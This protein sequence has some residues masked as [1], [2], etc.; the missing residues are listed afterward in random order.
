MRVRISSPR[1]ERERSAVVK[2][3][4][5]RVDCER[6]ISARRRIRDR[7]SLSVSKEQQA[8]VRSLAMRSWVAAPNAHRSPG[9]SK[10]INGLALNVGE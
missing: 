9:V 5:P 8:M 7:G 1:Q 2:R 6:A 3:E 10:V 4:T